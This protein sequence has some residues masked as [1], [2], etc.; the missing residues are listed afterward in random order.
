[1]V[2]YE[3][4]DMDFDPTEQNGIKWQTILKINSDNTI[5]INMPKDSWS[6]EEVVELLYKHTEYML[7]GKKDTLDKWIE[8]NL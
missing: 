7:S 8:E 6:R 4:I 1:M 2:E 5:D 3:N